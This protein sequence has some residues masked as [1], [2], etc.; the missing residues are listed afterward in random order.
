[1]GGTDTGKSTTAEA[2]LQDFYHRYPTSRILILDSKPRFRAERDAHGRSVKR[3]YRNWSHGPVVPGSAVVSEPAELDLAY[4]TGA[5]VAIA[6]GQ[7][8]RDVAALTG[9]ARRFLDTSR[10]NRPQLLV[11]DETMDFFSPNGTPRGGDDVLQ[12]VA[13]AGRE[14]GTAALYCTQR[15]RGIPAQLMEEMTRCYLFRLDYK[16]DVKRLWEMGF[17]Q[18][19]EPPTA[20]HSFLYWTKSDYGRVWGPYKLDL[21]KR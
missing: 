19:V 8:V 2:L 18:G 3:R 11:V 1:M 12:R 16:A 15:T 20:R 5:R 9:C 4:S 7:H 10:A 13:R 6:Q 14:R 21:P 17:P